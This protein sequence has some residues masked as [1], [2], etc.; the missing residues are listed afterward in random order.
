MLLMRDYGISEHQATM[1]VA[2]SKE[3]VPNSLERVTEAIKT[4]VEDW[5][6]FSEII[7][8]QNGEE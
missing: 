4:E 8:Y 2:A 1:A 5:V 3:L 6:Q 7:S